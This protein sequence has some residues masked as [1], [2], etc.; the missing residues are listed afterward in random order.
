MWVRFANRWRRG[1]VR[2][3]F[4][5][6]LVVMFLMSGERNEAMVSSSRK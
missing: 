6:V 4:L 2:L 5:W 3:D 1:K